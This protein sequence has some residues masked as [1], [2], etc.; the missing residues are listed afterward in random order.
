MARNL[1]RP[2]GCGRI[3]K[4]VNRV[5]VINTM[6][7]IVEGLVYAGKAAPD[8]EVTLKVTSAGAAGS[9][10]LKVFGPKIIAS[11]FKP[12]FM[13]DLQQKDLRLVLE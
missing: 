10:S 2:L 11:N 12:G 9:R 1:L 7:S 5:V 8:L 3:T 4:L 6:M 13:V